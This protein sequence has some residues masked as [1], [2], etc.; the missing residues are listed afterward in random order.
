M[1]TKPT[2]KAVPLRTAVAVLVV[3]GF[4]IGFVFL[5]V[6]Q[7]NFLVGRSLLPSTL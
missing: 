3:L 1:K 5:L 4:L 2:P 6:H 7:A